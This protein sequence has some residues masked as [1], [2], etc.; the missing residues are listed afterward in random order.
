LLAE[1]IED[2]AE[3]SVER[4]LTHVY[5]LKVNAAWRHVDP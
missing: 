1:D 5:N 2:V 3:H 4:I